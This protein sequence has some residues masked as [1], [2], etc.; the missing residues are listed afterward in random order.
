MTKMSNQ[1]RTTG[2]LL[3]RSSDRPRQRSYE[4]RLQIANHLVEALKL[5][6]PDRQIS[7]SDTLC[8]RDP[9]RGWIA[10]RARAARRG[11][12]SRSWAFPAAPQMLR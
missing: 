1:V 5:Y 8:W 4:E 7:L 12:P 6:Y 11:L 3:S 10:S 9:Y 2:A